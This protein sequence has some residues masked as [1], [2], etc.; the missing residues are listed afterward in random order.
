VLLKFRIVGKE[1]LTLSLLMFRILTNNTKN[2]T[3]FE[4]LAF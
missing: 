4:H 2:T 1:Y 3:S